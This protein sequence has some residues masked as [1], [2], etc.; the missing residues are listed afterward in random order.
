MGRFINYVNAHKRGA[1]IGVL[2]FVCIAAL[3]IGAYAM[4]PRRQQLVPGAPSAYSLEIAGG[5]LYLKEDVKTL[6]ILGI[7][8]TSERDP[9]PI[10]KSVQLLLYDQGQNSM[11]LYYLPAELTLDAVYL[12]DSAALP[13]Q[14]MPLMR[15]YSSLY[16]D[17]AL[18][19]QSMMRTVSNA[20][21]GIPIQSCIAL[22]A[23][24]LQQWVMG[25]E[26]VTLLLDSDLYIRSDLSLPAG[27]RRIS[28]H[29]AD[30]LQLTSFDQQQVLRPFEI[31]FEKYERHQDMAYA[32][33][34]RL[35]QVREEDGERALMPPNYEYS[36]LDA[37]Q[38]SY[39]M[40][41]YE[42]AAQ[43]LKTSAARIHSQSGEE[44]IFLLDEIATKEW[45]KK[46]FF[47]PLPA[48]S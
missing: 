11:Q 37:T 36:T 24:Q 12:D 26:Y 44:R 20:L 28:E 21:G 42:S 23:A 14:K 10:A 9:T 15:V 5:D 35:C 8:E 18:C 40:D 27:E 45:L 3:F 4:W 6:L 22:S 25:I 31:D 17:K 19:A 38:L 16:A 41:C 2:A 1:C 13:P 29:V 30:F 43:H 32:L 47:A 46:T 34:Q 48:A 7:G 39:W 33:L